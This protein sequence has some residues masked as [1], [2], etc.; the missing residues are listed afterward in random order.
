MEGTKG[1]LRSLGKMEK[2]KKFTCFHRVKE[3]LVEVSKNFPTPFSP[4][5]ESLYRQF[6]MDVIA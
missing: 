5:R 3:R 1:C 6:S 2:E 4:N